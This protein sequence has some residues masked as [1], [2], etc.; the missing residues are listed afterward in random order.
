MFYCKH[1]EFHEELIN[2]RLELHTVKIRAV[3]FFTTKITY[4]KYISVYHNCGKI[5][6][7]FTLS[8]VN[9]LVSIH[10]SISIDKCPA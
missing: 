4:T 10:Q 5:A 7:D 8:S 6:R 2:N 1:T 3:H 9:K